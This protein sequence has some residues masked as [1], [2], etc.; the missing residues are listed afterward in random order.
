MNAQEDREIL[1]WAKDISQDSDALMKV[2]DALAQSVEF[3]ALANAYASMP[4]SMRGEALKQMADFAVLFM[5]KEVS[6]ATK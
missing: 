5:V 1:Q 3:S 4:Q 2:Q 6:Y